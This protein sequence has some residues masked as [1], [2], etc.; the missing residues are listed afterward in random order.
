MT[1]WPAQDSSTEDFMHDHEKF[2]EACLLSMYWI[3]L[4]NDTKFLLFRFP[5]LNSMDLM[6]CIL[7]NPK[8]ALGQ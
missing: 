5:S 8:H 7:S 2:C 1:I 3:G 6:C 4:R